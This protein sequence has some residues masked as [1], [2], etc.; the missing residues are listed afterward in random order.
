[1]LC[2][3]FCVS[4]LCGSMKISADKIHFFELTI[5]DFFTKVGRE[6]LPWRKRKVT[7]YEVWVSE[8]MLQQTQVSRVIEYY[9]R[10]LNQFPTVES[11]AKTSWEEFLPYYEGLGYY[12]RGRNMQK[13]AQEIVAKHRGKFPRDAEALQGLPGI[14]PYTASAILSFAYGENCLAWDT[15]LQRVIGRFFFGSKNTF[16]PSV[17]K[18]R[19]LPTGRQGSSLEKGDRK[20]ERETN[21][22]VMTEYMEAKFSLPAKTLNA[23]LM[24]FGSAL[25][26]SRPKCEACPLKTR[27]VYYAEKGN[28]ELRM[29][30]DE[31]KK[32]IKI[33]VDWKEANALV[34]LHEN[35]RK[36]FSANTKAYKPFVL[37]NGYHSRAGIKSWFQKKYGLSVSV[38]PPHQKIVINKR[39]MMLVNVQILSGEHDF[40]LFSKKD[41]QAYTARLKMV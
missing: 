1:M 13:A 28:G 35:H 36:Y 39:P 14:G 22:V 38:R 31:L 10:F 34:F 4:V 24:D 16:N 12:A 20:R 2:L 15:N 19:H 23:A 40:P 26:L 30:G 21:G 32:K 3:E 27:C 7:A 29:A 25:C 9:T 18:N 37:E 17:S 11:L 33:K 8:V 6:H 41:Y 5:A